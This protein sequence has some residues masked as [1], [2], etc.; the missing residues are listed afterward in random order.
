RPGLPLRL[1]ED[2][3]LKVP[4]AKNRAHWLSE[5]HTE[6]EWMDAIHNCRYS[7]GVIGITEQFSPVAANVPG[8]AGLRPILVRYERRRR[9]LV[10][11]DFEVFAS[12]HWNFNVRNFN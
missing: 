8:P 1:F 5:S 11:P 9:E 6:L 3:E 4:A 10:Q 12:D 2:Q 7:N